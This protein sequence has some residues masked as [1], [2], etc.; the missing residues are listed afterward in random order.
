[1]IDLA[2]EDLAS[3]TDTIIAQGAF[4]V[5][6]LCGKCITL[7]ELLLLER[8]AHPEHEVFIV[9]KQQFRQVN[10]LLLAL[11]LIFLRLC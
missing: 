9:V 1:M 4:V 2:H 6:E 3:I 8:G 10:M 5:I 7:V 11:R